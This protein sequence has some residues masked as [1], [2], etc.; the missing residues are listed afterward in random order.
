[1]KTVKAS[2]EILETRNLLSGATAASFG[3][4]PAIA[5]NEVALQAIRVANTTP[6][7]AARDLAITQLA[8]FDAV[9]SVVPTARPYLVHLHAPRGTS[10]DAAAVGAAYE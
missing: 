4:N 7:A 2:T 10:A 3:I 1:M 8:V 6:P 9:N 5:W